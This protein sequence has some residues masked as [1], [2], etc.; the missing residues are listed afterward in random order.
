MQCQ[1]LLSASACLPAAKSL[2][3]TAA[4]STPNTH[5][6]HPPHIEPGDYSLKPPRIRASAPPPPP[7]FAASLA[8]VP[9]G[10]SVVI[11]HEFL[12]AMPVHQFEARC[13]VRFLCVLDCAM[14]V[15]TGRPLFE[16]ERACFLPGKAKWRAS[17]HLP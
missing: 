4:A 5:P 16:H 3:I 14:C 9:Q 7:L 12:D 11:A 6:P 15:R 8:T 2:L 1:F 17:F 10:P 13:R